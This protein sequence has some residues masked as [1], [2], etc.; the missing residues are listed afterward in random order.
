MKQ[1]T[2][3]TVWRTLSEAVGAWA[4]SI[5]ATLEYHDGGLVVTI[6]PVAAKGKRS[7][8]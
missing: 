3:G 8:K 5:Q 2:D 6:K 4:K 1:I 7:K